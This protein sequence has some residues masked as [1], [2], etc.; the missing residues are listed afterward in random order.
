MM[1]ENKQ[2]MHILK[3]FEESRI[4][5]AICK[6]APELI[7]IDSILGGILYTIDKRRKIH[8]TSIRRAYF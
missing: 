7:I 4:R 1:M 8:R 2:H 6:H 3:A 5:T